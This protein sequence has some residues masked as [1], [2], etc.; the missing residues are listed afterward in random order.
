MRI[1]I[2]ACFC[3]SWI[4]KLKGRG[5]RQSQA[6]DIQLSWDSSLDLLVIRGIWKVVLHTQIF[7]LVYH[8]S[9]TGKNP[10][11]QN[12]S[13]PTCKKGGLQYKPTFFSGQ[14]LFLSLQN[15]FSRKV[16]ADQ[17]AECIVEGR[18]P[19]KLLFAFKEI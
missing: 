13:S 19:S 8:F 2:S 17:V 10:S 5:H 4:F 16:V 3:Q 14:P 6:K 15:H 1:E 9:R 12:H 11:L 18:N 7:F